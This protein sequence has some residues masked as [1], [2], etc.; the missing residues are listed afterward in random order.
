MNDVANNLMDIFNCNK[1]WQ[2]CLY[3]F[4]YKNKICNYFCYRVRNDLTK[5]IKEN[6]FIFDEIKSSVLSETTKYT[7]MFTVDTNE[8]L[9]ERGNHICFSCQDFE[10]KFKHLFNNTHDL[11]FIN[12]T[13]NFLIEDDHDIVAKINLFQ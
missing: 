6:Y 8:L 10:M 5:Y 9:I 2:I 4:T 11:L 3:D 13:F 7:M 12:E 1:D